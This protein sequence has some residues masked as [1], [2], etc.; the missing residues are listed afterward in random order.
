MVDGAF[1]ADA[2]ALLSLGRILETFPEY[3]RPAWLEACDR[4][5]RR[6]KQHQRAYAKGTTKRPLFSTE[7]TGGVV[8][9]PQT[10]VP[11]GQTTGEVPVAQ[12]TGVTPVSQTIGITPTVLPASGPIGPST[13]VGVTGLVGLPEQA[14]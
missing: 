14:P 2:D 12:A 4:W 13:P 6:L 11:S 3:D 9:S 10:V 5:D 8:G 1:A 7:V